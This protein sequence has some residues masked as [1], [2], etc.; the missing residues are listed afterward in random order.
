MLE[1]MFKSRLALVLVVVF[2]LIVVFLFVRSLLV[3]LLGDPLAFCSLL[4]RIAEEFN[5]GLLVGP[6]L[7]RAGQ[8]ILSSHENKA[9]TLLLLIR[10][11]L[12]RAKSCR[13]P[14]ESRTAGV[15]EVSCDRNDVRNLI[16]LF[17][18]IISLEKVCNG[19]N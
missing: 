17:L 9:Q 2:L 6:L 4:L 14:L 15:L 3:L 7:G 5:N 19:A 13:S 18:V 1:L 12:G 8:R 16:G 11:R 10:V